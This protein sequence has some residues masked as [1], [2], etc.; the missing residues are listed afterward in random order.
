MTAGEPG[1]ASAA[2]SVATSPLDDIPI[3]TNTR[4]ADPFTR[5]P[6]DRLDEEVEP[7]N[8]QLMAEE[9]AAMRDLAA[10]ESQDEDTLDFEEEDSLGPRERSTAR[11]PESMHFVCPKQ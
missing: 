3:S 1:E 5:S 8:A 6:R 2:A 10:D 7:D 4:D 9:E 11:G